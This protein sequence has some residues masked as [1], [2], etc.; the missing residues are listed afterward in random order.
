MAGAT[1]IISG[2]DLSGISFFRSRD[3]LSTAAIALLITPIPAG[4]DRFRCLGHAEEPKKTIWT[5]DIQDP[6]GFR[7]PW[8]S[9]DRTPDFSR[10]EDELP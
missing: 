9:T 10:K 1:R 4:I 3:N 5:R 8:S 2:T 6:S 7:L